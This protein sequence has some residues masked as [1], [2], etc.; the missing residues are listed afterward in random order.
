[1]NKGE[2]IAATF[3]VGQPIFCYHEDF[4]IKQSVVSKIDKHIVFYRNGV[5]WITIGKDGRTKEGRLYGKTI[6]ELRSKM[7]NEFIDK[8]FKSMMKI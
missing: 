8:K 1:M 7:I 2:K 5:N 4:T 3:K 6:R